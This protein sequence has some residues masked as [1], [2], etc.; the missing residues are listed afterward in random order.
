MTIIIAAV[1][2][3]APFSP[4]R[5]SLTTAP[6]S[7]PGS[8]NFVQDWSNNIAGHRELSVWMMCGLPWRRTWLTIICLGFHTTFKT[9]LTLSPHSPLQSRYGSFPLVS[10]FATVRTRCPGRN[11][12]SGNETGIQIPGRTLRYLSVESVPL[13][14]QIVLYLSE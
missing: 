9:I 14:S 4:G 2:P 11:P 7:K 12:K 13:N 10:L 8:T 1:P 5:E 3:W 6:T